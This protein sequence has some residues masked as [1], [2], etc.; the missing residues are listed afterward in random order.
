MVLLTFGTGVEFC[1]KDR[2]LFKKLSDFGLF[3]K[4]VYRGKQ[5]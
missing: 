1:E 3:D 2:V 4:P 5:Q